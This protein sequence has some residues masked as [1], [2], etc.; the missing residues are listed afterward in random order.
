MADFKIILQ[1][2]D[3]MMI[4]YIDLQINSHTLNHLIHPQTVTP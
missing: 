1:E 3:Y 4:A 2:C